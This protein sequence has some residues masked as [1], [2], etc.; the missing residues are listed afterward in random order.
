MKWILCFSRSHTSWVNTF[1]LR[2]QQFLFICNV[3]RIAYHS[4][5]WWC[6]SNLL[7]YFNYWL[8]QWVRIWKVFFW[9]CMLIYK[10]WVSCRNLKENENR[11]WFDTNLRECYCVLKMTWIGQNQWIWLK[12]SRIIVCAFLPFPKKK[13]NKKC[14]NDKLKLLE[15]QTIN[16]SKPHPFIDVL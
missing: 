13:Q 5:W 14:K 11:N 8:R 9:R 3:N 15:P 7:F 2:R 1:L 6:T 4:Q 12:D 10:L 16:T